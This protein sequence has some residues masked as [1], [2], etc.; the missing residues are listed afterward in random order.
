M[1]RRR[2]PMIGRKVRTTVLITGEGYGE[3]LLLKHIRRLYTSDGNGHS[4]TVG[5]ARGKGARQVIDS[6]IKDPRRL[7]HDVTWALFD[8]DTDWDAGVAA[9]AEDKG[10]VVLLS[11]PCLEAWLL[12]AHGVARECSSQEHKEEFQRRFGG[13]VHDDGVLEKH[14]PKE[15][16]DAA[17]AS[18]P[19]LDSILRLLGV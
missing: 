13:A 12:R 7:S 18:M 16:L 5:N 17:R 4:L 6:A 15:R 19:V 8:T 14:F 3:Q 9:R 1:A 2:G 11:E 10:I